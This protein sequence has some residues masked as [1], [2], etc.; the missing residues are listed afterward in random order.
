M[1]GFGSVIFNMFF[2]ETSFICVINIKDVYHEMIDYLSS[3]WP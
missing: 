2:N 1:K 3:Y